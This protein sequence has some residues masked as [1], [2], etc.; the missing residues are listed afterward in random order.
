MSN[1]GLDRDRIEALS[2][3]LL[4]LEHIR[5]NYKA[6]PVSRDRVYEALNVLAF[7]V[8]TV[9]QGAQSSDKDFGDAER[10]FNRALEIQ[11][12]SLIDDPPETR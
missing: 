12:K 4:E 11:I 10:F 7:C 5:A 8:A 2:V 6:G 9:V 1:E 3:A